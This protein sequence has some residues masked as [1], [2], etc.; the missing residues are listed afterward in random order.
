MRPVV[1]QRLL[2]DEP[3]D[4]GSRRLARAH[5]AAPA[6]VR[7]AGHLEPQAVA[8]PEAVGDRA[9]VDHNAEAAVGLRLAHLRRHA[10][11]PVAA[12]DRAPVRPDIAEPAHKVRV[13]QR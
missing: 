7:A 3:P 4:R 13:G 6:R 5:I 11:Q 9:E 1:V 2:R 10:D 12:V 8:A